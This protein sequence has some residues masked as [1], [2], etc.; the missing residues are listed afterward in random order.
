MV[1][2]RCNQFSLLEEQGVF[3]E[4]QGR[5]AGIANGGRVRRKFHAAL[6]GSEGDPRGGPERCGRGPG[7]IETT[8]VEAVKTAVSS[9]ECER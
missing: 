6:A 4:L 8:A 7:Y 5:K 9:L 1:S 3:F 2:T